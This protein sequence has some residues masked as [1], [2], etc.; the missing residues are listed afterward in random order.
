MENLLSSPVLYTNSK[1]VSYIW[2]VLYLYILTSSHISE[3]YMTAYF[4][5]VCDILFALYIHFPS[6]SYHLT[7]WQ[8]QIYRFV[9]VIWV[10]HS[11]VL[12]D[13]SSESCVWIVWQ[14]LIGL[15]LVLFSSFE[16]HIFWLNRL[17]TSILFDWTVPVAVHWLNSFSNCIEFDRIVYLVIYYLLNR[18]PNRVCW[19]NPL[20]AWNIWCRLLE[21][22][23]IS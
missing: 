8:K 1:Y 3:I 14:Y 16:L 6:A 5:Y 17:S 9:S 7:Q 10:E 19:L 4:E 21:L 15:F 2:T 23:N 13:W 18:S 12:W 11:K 20:E 22:S